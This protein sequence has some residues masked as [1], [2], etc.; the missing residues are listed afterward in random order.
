MARTESRRRIG[1][2]VVKALRPGEI[3][4]D[5][6]VKG[7]GVR[8]QRKAAVYV[9]KTRIGG[10]QRWFSI[11]PHGAPWTPEKARQR[12]RVILGEKADRKDPAAIRDARKRNP[13][14][15]ELAALFLAEHVEAKRKASTAA[16]YRDLIE[17]LVVP[18]MG[19]F[20]TAD[21]SHADVARLHH[22]LR[23][24]PYQANRA[25]AVL[26]KMFGWAEGRGYRP[27]LANPCR[28]V[29]KYPERARERF[30]SEAELARLGDVLA[31]AEAEWEA[32]H[33]AADAARQRGGK[34]PR[35]T[36][37]LVSPTVV[38]AIR[39][40]VFTGARMSEVLTLTWGMV[41]ADRAMLRLPDSKTGAKSIYLNAPALAVLAALP[42]LEGNP[43]VLP[44]Q[45]DGA[46]LVNLEK[47]WRILRARAGLDDVR[48][49][50]LRHSFASVAAGLGQSLPMI[51]RLLGHTQAATTQRYAHLASDPVRQA[52]DAVGARI[53]AA[54]AG[55]KGA[56]VVPIG[57]DPRRHGRG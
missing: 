55:R 6:E 23:A 32:H 35:A 38:A 8:R 19:A 44:G 17:R 56:E 39:L 30:L 43:H 18:A 13:T 2:Q 34:A 9:L 25:I 52:A 33:A 40:L 29:E 36:R 20:R 26:S 15:E 27:S 50:D 16:G 3:V 54:I 41:D 22:S 42:R 53:A 31:G 14:V 49:H 51:G 4:W 28:H 45:K 12:A 7:F 5:T 57:D 24:T 10:R 11:G 21:V 47:P 46:P 37:D 48:L 1:L